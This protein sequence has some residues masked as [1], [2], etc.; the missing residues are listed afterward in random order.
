M[1][2]QYTR[3]GKA[4]LA[5][6]VSSSEFGVDLETDYDGIDGG[7]YGH[8]LKVFVP[9][10]VL[11][12]INIGEESSLED[13]LRSDVN[14]LCAAVDGEYFAAVRFL[15]SEESEGHSGGPLY[16]L[17]HPKHG[18][19]VPSFWGDDGVRVFI[20]HR[21]KHKSQVHAIAD[22]LKEYGISSFVA[23][24]TIE[25]MSKWKDE[26][27]K[28]LRSAEVML[29]FLT[30]GFSESIW[31]NQEIGFALCRDIPIVPISLDGS[32]P[33]GFLSDMQTVRFRKINERSTARIYDLIATAVGDEDRMRTALVKAL[34]DSPSFDETKKRFVRLK[35]MTARVTDEEER[36]LVDGF[37]ENSQLN[38]C[39]YLGNHYKRFEGFLRRSTGK[40]YVVR[41]GRVSLPVA[42]SSV[43]DVPF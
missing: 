23:H 18:I 39:F 1:E 36:M 17:R 24:D 10:D 15:D 30:E 40:Q 14:A 11:K 34:V 41:K 6:L 31:T 16:A 5:T 20:T 22:A 4:L 37:N 3:D 38:Q 7:V 26:I 28:G 29:A 19:A 2:S 43:D 35:K 12:R 13:Q 33:P 42:K 21:D 32:T 8:D 25:P 9:F 27:V